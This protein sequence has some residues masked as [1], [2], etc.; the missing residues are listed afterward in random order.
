MAIY[1][2][3]HSVEVSQTEYLDSYSSLDEA[4]RRLFN[5]GSGSWSHPSWTNVDL[6]PQTAAYAAIQAPC[7]HHDLVAESALPFP[8][9]L[10]DCIYCSHVVEHIPEEAVRNFMREAFRCLD[11]GGCLRIVTGP[12]ADLDWQALLR[13]DRNWWFW[14][15]EAEFVATVE[16]DL[17]A[18]SVY[19]RWLH[20]LATPRSPYSTTPCDE[21]FNASRLSALVSR[22]LQDPK[23]L[24]DMLTQALPFNYDSPGDH[25]SWWNY[26]KLERFLRNS[27]FRTIFRSGY[28]Q[29][30][31]RFM[32]DLR[33]F[34]QS[35]PQ[36]SVYVEA[37]K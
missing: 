14:M 22:H 11:T 2:R 10:A 18:M 34:D 24:L 19:D 20:H 12:C 9:G 35:Y 5:I 21:K 27:G 13:G 29:S 6:P 7:V 37:I 23:P 31:S 4:K 28:G 1:Q 32:R 25:I 8:S 3:P 30:T 16:R 26:K 33:Y 36:I 15:N 17:G